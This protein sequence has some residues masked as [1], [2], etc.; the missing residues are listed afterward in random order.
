LETE[1]DQKARDQG[2]EEE[3]VEAA[4]EWVAIVLEQ[5]RRE[6]V[7]AQSAA[8]KSHIK[9]ESHVTSRVAQNAGQKWSE[10]RC[11]THNIRYHETHF[12]NALNK[13]IQ[14]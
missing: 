10:N 4:A 13:K 3:W 14:E 12:P 1:Q 9:S 2:Q 7:F 8:R 6:N 5:V 11:L